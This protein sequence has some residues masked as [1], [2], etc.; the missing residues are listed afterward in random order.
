MKKRIRAIGIRKEILEH[1]NSLDKDDIAI[2]DVEFGINGKKTKIMP[3]ETGNAV[4]VYAEESVEN[5]MVDDVEEEETE[6]Q[7]VSDCC[8]G[9]LRDLSKILNGHYWS[10]KSCGEP[11]DAVEPDDKIEKIDI[12]AAWAGEAVNRQKINEIIE[13]INNE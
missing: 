10:C 11:C 3:T 8:G 4:E 12:E 13:K 1:Y 7:K 9:E 5:N 2:T 6:Q